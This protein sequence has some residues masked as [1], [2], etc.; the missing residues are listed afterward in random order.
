MKIRNMRNAKKKQERNKYIQ[1]K[2]LPMVTLSTLIKEIVVN[3]V[4]MESSSPG[5]NCDTGKA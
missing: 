2:F 4:A 1:T 5:R 3:T